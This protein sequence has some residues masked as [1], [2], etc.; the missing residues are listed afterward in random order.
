MTQEIQQHLA[1]LPPLVT[2]EILA[3]KLGIKTETLYQRLWRQKKTPSLNLLP[4]QFPIPGCNKVAFARQSCLDWWLNC[5]EQHVKVVRKSRG[6]PT[7]ASEF[8]GK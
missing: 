3:A 6:R 5:A 7:I 2:A 4:P 1:D 8:G